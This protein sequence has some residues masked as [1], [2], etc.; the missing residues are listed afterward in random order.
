MPI[1][2]QWW[3]VWYPGRRAGRRQLHRAAHARLEDR[4]G[5]AR[6]ACCS[7]T[8]RTTCCGRGRGSSSASLADRLSRARRHPARRSRT[9]I[10]GCIGHDI[11]YPAMLRFL[12]AGFVGLMVGG[13]ARRQLVDDPHAPELG[14]VV[15]GA[16]LLSPLPAARRDRGA[17]R[18]WPAASRRSCCSSCSSATV[19]ALDTAQERLR[20]HPA[21]RRRHRA[22][23]PGALV[24][25]ARQRL[26]RDR[27]DGQ[28][29]CR[30][31]RAADPGPA[32]AS[33]CRRTSR[34]SSP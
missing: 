22:A 26:V 20:P 28:L 14:R 7:S 16:R 17:L 13:L 23:L 12:P 11:A 27:R 3:A 8:S 18:R 19:Y 30:L 10:R 21:G 5:R 2:V 24:L 32:A 9:S 29:A 31:G 6:R 4:E 1:A 15:P 34:W 25:V 33:G